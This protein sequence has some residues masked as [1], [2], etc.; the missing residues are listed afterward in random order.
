MNVVLRL[1]PRMRIRYF[2]FYAAFGTF[3][4]GNVREH[5]PRSNSNE[6]FSLY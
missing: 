3:K 5:T 6:F 1:I 4:K 2:S